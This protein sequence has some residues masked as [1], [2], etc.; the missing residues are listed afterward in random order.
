MSAWGNTDSANN[1]PLIPKER[2]TRNFIYLTTANST[3]AGVKSIQFTGIGAL[4]AAN[5][6]VLVGMAAST[7]NTVVGGANAPASNSSPATA[8]S[9]INAPLPG[10]ILP[11]SGLTKPG[12]QRANNV[13]TA[14]TG[15]LVTF[16]NA[17]MLFIPPGAAV[18]FDTIIPYTSS[19]EAN[20]Y[21]RD[22]I[23]VTPSRIVNANV[24]IANTHTGW[25]HV[26]RTV[27]S[28][29]TVR[30]RKEVLVALA[31]STATNASSANTSQFGIYRGV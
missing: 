13:V 29:G 16:A 7:P 2:E 27:N 6:G 8:L 15:N 4:T 24:T 10:Q 21:N 22:V 11:T 18:A 30:Y 12:F 26:Y 17:T 20:T 3:V 19:E 9:V 14:V 1:K 25:S 5:L 23:L 31:N 28:D